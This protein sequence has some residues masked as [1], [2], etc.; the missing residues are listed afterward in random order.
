MKTFKTAVAIL[1]GFA[2][3]YI[4]NNYM[5]EK[6]ENFAFYIV[7]GLAVFAVFWSIIFN[8][9]QQTND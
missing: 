2:L 8:K 5:S 4:P 6:Y 3:S 7:I 1:I 9:K